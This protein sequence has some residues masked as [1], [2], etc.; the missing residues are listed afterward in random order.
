MAPSKLKP[1]TAINVRHI[2]C[3]KHSKKE[4]ALDR[5]VRGHKFD[6]VA[7]E[8]S[9]DKARQGMFNIWRMPNLWWQTLPKVTIFEVY[10]YANGGKIN[11]GGSL[12]WKMRGSLLQD[13]EK[14]AY[15]LVPSTTAAPKW[16]EVKTGEGYH[17]IMVEGRR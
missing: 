6:D 5:L 3:E 9:E 13:F 16:G 4:Q 10:T 17:I 11:I 2:L 15:E 8:L 1:A 7:R 12:G 14:V